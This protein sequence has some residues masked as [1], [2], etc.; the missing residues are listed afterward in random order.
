MIR[1]HFGAGARAGSRHPAGALALCLALAACSAQEQQEPAPIASADLYAVEMVAEGLSH[2]W[3]IEFLPDGDMLVTE[4]T[5][6][7]RLISGGALRADPV[8]G[9]PAVYAEGQGGLLDVLAAPDF[10]D[11]GI[12]F[13]SYAMGDADANTTEVS[14]YRLK[15]GALVDGQRIFTADP[16]RDTSSHFGGRMTVLPDG[17]I[18]LTLGDA[19]AYREQAQIRD[20]HLGTI[21]R[22]NP[23]GSI[24]ADNPFAGEDG[25]AAYVLSYGHRNVQGIAWD[26]MREQLWAHEHGP[27]GG[28]ELN[29]ITPGANYG[30]P[31][32]T[33]GWDYSGARISPTTS[34]DGFEPPEKVWTPS[35]APA[36]LA[37]YSGAAHEAWAGDLFV[38]ALAGRALHHL[39]LDAEG[40]IL[41]EHRL[42]TERD[43]RIRQVA[44]GPDGALYVL[45][46][47]AENGEVLRVTPTGAQPSRDTPL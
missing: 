40:D 21:V 31:I 7:L 16:L 27:R 17:T 14:R 6:A 20:N 37:W 10:E 42:L 35:I 47:D 32:A 38:A 44:E 22:F 23:D 12:V 29:V 30:W 8:E 39:E 3:D 11:S 13:L 45:T 19:F 24:P 18:V 41:A 36:G 28:D 15:D 26:P 4:R 2:P 25:P 43:A 1:H 9:A 34:H 5:G 33:E 46:D